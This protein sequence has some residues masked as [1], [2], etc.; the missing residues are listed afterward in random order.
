MQIQLAAVCVR[1]GVS[2]EIAHKAFMRALAAR[3]GRLNGPGDPP[4]ALEVEVDGQRYAVGQ[5]DDPR[6]F[7]VLPLPFQGHADEW[8][9]IP[10]LQTADDL[11]QLL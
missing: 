8:K 1:A 10:P 3:E 7:V 4:W 6:F 9:V 2:R 5:G 11:L